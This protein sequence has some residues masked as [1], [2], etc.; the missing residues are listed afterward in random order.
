M[1]AT[2][3][4][5]CVIAALSAGLAVHAQISA[6]VLGSHNLSPGSSSP[7]TGTISA[8]CLYCHAPHSSIGGTTVPV[9]LW[10]QKL[11][12]V[13]SYQTY[14]SSTMV[15]QTNPS[16]PLGSDSTLCLSCHDGTVAPGTLQPWG[17]VPMIGSMNSADILGT[18]LQAVHPFSFVL[19]LKANPADLVA[20]LT[21]TP[22]STAD[23]TGAV[24]LING[25]VECT[26]CHNPH[27]QNID[28]NS[29]FLVINNST[30]ALCLA[31]HST[32]PSGS[33][34][35]M[36]VAATETA[37][38]IGTGAA[39]I[40]GR[41]SDRI[42]PLEGWKASIHA[43]ASNR[44]AGQVSLDAYSASAATTEKRVTLGPYSTV[45]QNGCLSCHTPHNAKSPASLLRG[46][47]DQACIVCHAGSPNVAPAAPD[48]LAEMSLPKVGHSFPQATH[49]HQA[50]ESALLNQ[51]RHANCVDCHN[52][53]SS[54]RVT[55][56]E[57]APDMRRSQGRVEGI[58][59]ADGTS[60]LN[61]AV[62]QYENCLRCHGTSTGKVVSPTFGY[63][64]VR[65][66]SALDPLNVIPQFSVIASS[67]HPVMHDR[68]SPYPQPS[69]RA[70]MLDL[71]GSTPGRSMGI[72]ILCTDCHNSDDNREF[73]GRGPNGPHGSAYSHILERRYE[74]SQTSVPGRPI[75]N[76]F[77][78]PNISAAG[79]ANG[80]PYA[81]CAK[82]HDLTRVLSNSSFSE[83]ARHVKQDG[84]SCSVCHTAHGMGAHVA[85]DS[86]ER[87]VNF[88]VNVVAPNGPTPIGYSR[89][90]NS[91]S[92]VCHGV[93]HKLA[94]TAP[95]KPAS[96]RARGQ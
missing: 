1:K 78:S 47:S 30:S 2:L 75:T 64:P 51:N 91:C 87:L 7:I 80:G 85:T 96:P 3:F 65:A 46:S 58:S 68:S 89:A 57:G 31:C 79:G 13:Q 38:R 94:G 28:P 33:G 84:F 50:S 88:D 77:Q 8:P 66:V 72:R 74:F 32:I 5:V 55:V 69:L 23:T 17:Q 61:P 14:T 12:S 92:L 15:N 59:A 24:K 40:T 6:D 37:A 52:A 73:G 42:N 36:A 25:N 18:N 76:L 29:S 67:S 83:H 4:S 82:C 21:S 39:Q 60:V 48:V 81:L 20:S 95:T 54:S 71:D 9:P 35:G 19:P 86:G 10:S 56:F 41:I 22:P 27:V 26:S 34:M 43:T 63:A 11:S 45:A 70:N 16:P 53:H 62:N 90:S 93:T 44:V 49:P